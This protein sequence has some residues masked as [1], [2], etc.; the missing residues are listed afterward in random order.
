M[1]NYGPTCADTSCDERASSGDY[2]MT[3][4]PQKIQPS[5]RICLQILRG[6]DAGARRY[7]LAHQRLPVG[8]G[9]QNGL[10]LSDG[11]VS[12][13]HGELCL[14]D[15]ELVY[16]DLGSRH[17]SVVLVDNQQRKL[18]GAG[19]RPRVVLNSGAQIQVGRTLLRVEIEPPGE[20]G[21]DVFD[22]GPT[23]LSLA[24]PDAPIDDTR[25]VKLSELV[26]TDPRFEDLSKEF[27]AKARAS[28]AES[29]ARETMITTALSGVDALPGDISGATDSL[30]I[31]FRLA[32]EL[33]SLNK[34]DDIL[35]LIVEAVF[36]AFGA[37]NFFAITLA[38]DPE[39]IAGTAPFLTRER[40][41][42]ERRAEQVSAPILSKSLIKQVVKTRQSVLFVR[43]SLGDNISQSILDAQITAC[44][45]APLVGQHSLLGIMQVDTR[46]MGGL[47][48][49][50]DLDLFGV[51]AS[52][53][54]FAVERARLSENI[55]E[56]FESFVAA[57]VNAIEARDP[58]TA[59]HSERVADY[60]M[61]LAGAANQIQNGTFSEFH[62]DRAELKELRYAALLHDFGKIAVRE[63]VL[64]KEARLPVDQLK[65][66]SQ[67][68][69]TI[70]A[71]NYRR[72]IR[73]HFGDNNAPLSPEIFQQLE[74]RYA[75]S[76]RELD[77][78]M[79]FLAEVAQA[80][81]LRDEQIARVKKIAAH[82]Y[83]A[84]DG[85]RRELLSAEE[86][87]NLTIP[88]G[89]LNQREWED[90]RSHAQRSRDYL[91]QIPWGKELAR[92]PCI[93]GAHHEKLDGSG[94]PDGL[95]SDE[96]I[97]QVRMLTIAD[98]FDALTAA[99]RPYRK[100]ATIDGALKVLEMEAAGKKL[101]ADL[102][103]LFA[104]QVAPK[105]R[106]RGLDAAPAP[107]FSG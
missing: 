69:E 2:L 91:E 93:A 82:E 90:M 96:I 87:E 23:D 50:K 86:V 103:E 52:N 41:R 73:G 13:I 15:G 102:V 38:D 85:T 72:F 18:K 58:T 37:A 30:A 81:F 39:Q 75:K 20:A 6:P 66:I 34:I 40:G 25:E 21:E 62:L 106:A 54:A 36:E 7:F 99:D 77:E 68:I 84:H 44:L 24:T 78:A 46:G 101:D 65:L 92:I 56:M 3:Q 76:C 107:Q 83:L 88:R 19:E 97:P 79:A 100:A 80:P 59:G 43:D 10:V 14:E 57:S 45:C 48:S 104:A 60:T 1:I 51:F 11:Y 94:Y 9:L 55:V 8:R 27:G 35:E 63:S 16:R 4:A 89:T 31:L 33:N 95:S 64:N 53:V 12:N 42:L 22:P 67:R 74:E 5:Q 98:I 105:L 32:R 61:A 70:K 29:G 17:G 26:G 28:A 49:K 71:L 47:F